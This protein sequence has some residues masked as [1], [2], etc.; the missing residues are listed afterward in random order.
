[1]AR[2]EKFTNKTD[3]QEIY[4]ILEK[5]KILRLAMCE[6]E[7]PYIVPLIFAFSQD[8]GVIFFHSS[9]KGKKID[10]IKKNP[11]V[12]FQ[13]E[14][15]VEILPSDEPCKFS[16]QYKSVI[17]VGY[18]SV[19]KDEKTK[20]RALNLLSKKYGGRIGFRCRFK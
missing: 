6:N 15:D 9:K 4:N 3:K 19:I 12:S 2:K 10:L 14:I 20:L 13:T 17:G 16:M 5:S 1:M 8:D 11:R 18:C 7:L